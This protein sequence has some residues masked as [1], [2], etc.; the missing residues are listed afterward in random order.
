MPILIILLLPLLAL[1]GV[2]VFENKLSSLNI[3]AADEETNLSTLEYFELINHAFNFTAEELALLEKN[4]FI[5]LNRLAT[6]DVLD[7]Y[8]YYWEEDLPII[9]TTDTMLQVWHLIFDHTIEQSEEYLFF[10]LLRA[11]SLE[12]KETF[13]NQITVTNND[14]K[15]QDVLVYLSV[16]AKLADSTVDVPSAIETSTGQILNAIYDEITIFEAVEQLQ[17]NQTRRFI[18]DFSMYRPR[19]H[20]TRSEN[21]GKYFR[22]FKWFS[23]IPFF[24]EDYPGIIHLNRSPE[25][26]IHSALYLLFAMKNAQIAV[27]GLGINT[28]GI[29]VWEGFKKFLDPLVG[30]TYAV[31]PSVLD[32]I[33]ATVKGTDD[34]HPDEV[35]PADILAIQNQVLTNDSIPTPKDPFI[36]DAIV[37][38]ELWPPKLR[39]RVASGKTMVLFGE[40]LTLDTYAGNHLV[41]P[42][43]EGP[44]VTDD[45]EKWFPMGLEFATTVLESERAHSYLS[46]IDH[47]QY[48]EQLNNTREEIE[49]WPTHEKQTLAWKWMEVLQ[50]LSQPQPEF[51]ESSSPVTPDFMKTD[52]WLD[53]KLT[54]ILGSWAQLKH[55]TILYAKQG[56]T[57]PVCSTPE[58]YVEPY[59]RFYQELGQLSQTFRDSIA[60]LESLGLNS[61]FSIH[62]PKWYFDYFPLE[63]LTNF[64]MIVQKLE[65]IAYH[66][67]Q[68]QELTAEEKE[69][70]KETYATKSIMCSPPEVSGWLGKLL[71]SLK[72]EYL[73][74]QEDPNSRASAI[75][76]I[77]T[78]GNTKRTLEVATGFLEHLVVILPGWNG[79]EILAVGPVFS[80]Y[81]FLVPMEKRMTDKDWRG[82]LLAHVNETMS[83]K[84]SPSA[85]PGEYLIQNYEADPSYDFS[86]FDYNSSIFPR[87]FW[88]QSY[89]ASAEMPASI[90]Y[91]EVDPFAEE[92]TPFVPGRVQLLSSTEASTDNNTPGMTFFPLLAVLVVLTWRSKRRK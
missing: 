90:I 47:A 45:L 26:M 39:E 20:Y 52:A 49:N 28:T 9:I 10:P 74:M 59:P 54:T 81:E 84:A 31:T 76:D 38:L 27:D 88:A 40:R 6:D 37:P 44:W 13:A 23:R 16:A 65:G 14:M 60:Q 36:I 58:G 87:G 71:G 8:R 35:D 80:Y 75:A 11:F 33:T 34:W 55:D 29:E 15:V 56:L 85:L 2:Q 53:E 92:E 70:I 46:A 82:T 62:D 22:L 79:T 69:F 83:Q 73:V 5:V 43:V 19:G 18:D 17:S 42:F 72:E 4:E 67:L 91:E 25:E 12:V 1:S 7:A 78:D 24:F 41:Y 68:G 61:N 77:H 66:E 51:N 63:T 57:G 30:E 89:M 50:Q 21:L 3:A 86:I 48:Q 32:E 64:T